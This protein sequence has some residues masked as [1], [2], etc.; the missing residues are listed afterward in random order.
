M[1]VL[2]WNVEFLLQNTLVRYVMQVRRVR[3]ER[4]KEIGSYVFMQDLPSAQ[5]GNVDQHLSHITMHPFLPK[6]NE[7]NMQQDQECSPD[8]GPSTRKHVQQERRA[9]L[10]QGSAG[11]SYQSKGLDTPQVIIT[12]SR[13]SHQRTTHYQV[14]EHFEINC[15]F[16]L[17]SF[18][19]QLNCII[20]FVIDL[21]K[22]EISLCSFN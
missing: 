8:G 13:A 21:I 14:E 1:K 22:G 11:A 6:K 5:L 18:P 10:T 7:R 19:L 12:G 16:F 2:W 4:R 15:E 20:K 17:S 3:D 9:H